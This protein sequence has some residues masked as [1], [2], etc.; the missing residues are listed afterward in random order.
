MIAMQEHVVITGAGSGIGLATALRLDREGFWVT[1][2]L[3]PGSA[4]PDQPWSE[5][6]SFDHCDL[7]RPQEV[8]ALA[9]RLK[10][11]LPSLRLLHCNAGV[12]PWTCTLTEEGMELGYAT[13]PLATYVLA[14]ALLPLLK[15]T[16]GALLLV[17]GSLV[18]AWGENDFEKYAFGKDFDPNASYYAS[19]LAQ[20]LLVTHFAK[21]FGPLGVAVNSLEPG[22]TRTAF[23]RHFEGFYRVM[24]TLWRLFMRK[25]EAVADEVLALLRRPDL[26][27]TTGSNWYR[28]A[29]KPLNAKARDPEAANRLATA[30]AQW[31]AERGGSR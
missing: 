19:K 27:A 28:G 16:P 1:A 13:G 5:R 10:A 30:L 26:L 24:A 31:L 29:L 20:M 9:E 22:M 6:V 15:Q 18:H 7:S 12:Q 21:S 25:P 3:R 11:R 8:L 23:A 14:T 2:I 4:R 17:T